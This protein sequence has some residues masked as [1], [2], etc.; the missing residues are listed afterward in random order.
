VPEV[1]DQVGVG[2]RE[3]GVLSTQ[4]TEDAAPRRSAASGVA[5]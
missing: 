1:D 2:R 5:F 3:R 4:A